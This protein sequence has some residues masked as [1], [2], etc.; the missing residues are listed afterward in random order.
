MKLHR[1][2]LLST[3]YMTLALGGTAL[4]VGAALPGGDAGLAFAGVALAACNPCNPCNPCAAAAG[5]PCAAAQ[6]C[7]NP[8]NPCCPNPVL[9]P[10]RA[11]PTTRATPAIR[12]R[13][14]SDRARPGASAPERFFE[15]AR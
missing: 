8:C 5:N 3:T 14:S 6:D 10:T 12:A 4:L 11:R 15:A 2:R 9:R 13:P 1:S 7:P